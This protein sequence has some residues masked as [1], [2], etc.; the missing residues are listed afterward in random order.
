MQEI[1]VTIYRTGRA[2]PCHEYSHFPHRSWQCI[3]QA[4]LFAECIDGK[5]A[6][7]DIQTGDVIAYQ[8]QG[9]KYAYFVIRNNN[10]V[11][12]QRL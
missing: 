3:A 1:T 8:Y 2:T 9:T 11:S 12:V 10:G 4:N 6:D 7:M 5:Y